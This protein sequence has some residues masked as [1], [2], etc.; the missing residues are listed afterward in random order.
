MKS[1]TTKNMARIEELIEKAKKES[2]KKEQEELNATPLQQLLPLVFEDKRTIPNAFIRSA[3]FGMVKRGSRAFVQNQQVFSFHQYEINYTGEMLDQSDLSAWDT[4]VYLA[5][6]SNSNEILVTTR[7][8]ILQELGL[9]NTGLNSKALM[10]RLKRLQAGQVEIKYK[11][12]KGRAVWY[13][14]SLLDDV[15]VDETTS[16]LQIRFNKRLLTIFSDN[17]YSVIN[18]NYRKELGES[19]LAR[20][21]YHLY[22]SSDTLYPI[23]VDFLKKLSR[24]NAEL[25]EFRR[26]LKTAMN[27]LEQLGWSWN[28]SNDDKLIIQ[29]NSK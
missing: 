23:T 16:E 13:I 9:T 12:S 24:S 29:K 1:W 18:N 14:G 26:Q 10:A 3:L 22:S 4:V 27:D 11:N 8:K 20:W 17:D 7:Y 21:I 19:Q 25:K 15:L 2:L 6:T 28:I 5:K